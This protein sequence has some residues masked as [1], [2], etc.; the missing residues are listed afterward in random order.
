MKNKIAEERQPKDKWLRMTGIPL[1]T[2]V[3][4]FIL[5]GSFKGIEQVPI[6]QVFFSNLVITWAGWEISRCILLWARKRYPGMEQ[7]RKRLGISFLLYF[8]VLFTLDSVVTGLT[9]LLPFFTP[10]NWT[11]VTFILFVAM[12]TFIAMVIGSLYEAVYFFSLWKKTTREKEQLRHE[13]LMTQFESLKTQ[14][15][16]HFLFNSL[17]SLSSLVET[18]KRIAVEFI[19]GMAQVYRYILDSTE[20]DL[21][22]LRQE[23]SFLHAYFYL[24]KTRFGN[25]L[26]ETISVPESFLNMRIPPLTLQ[27]LVENAVK[28]NI[29]SAGKPLFLKIAASGEDEITICNN[30]QKKSGAVPSSHFG[31]KNINRRYELLSMQGI[32]IR[33]DAVSWCVSISLLKN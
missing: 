11:P 13:N 31:L 23:L 9:Y 22:T 18:D 30:L 4:T 3:A 28:H 15:N 6:I 29:V 17:N 16:P 20:S 8:I 33:E 25:N 10:Y 19:H 27:I 2:L 5:S 26:R 1:V 7:V 21:T 12:S 32:R 24:L 14:I